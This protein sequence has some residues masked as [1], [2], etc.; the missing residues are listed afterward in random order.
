MAGVVVPAVCVERTGTDLSGRFERGD[1]LVD[2]GNSHYI[3]DIR[4][5][6]QLA[7]QGLHYV[8]AGRCVNGGWL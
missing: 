8:D 4:R 2:G 6:K 5:A 7:T 3:D 1:V